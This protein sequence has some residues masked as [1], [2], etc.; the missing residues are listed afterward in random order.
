MNIKTFM[1]IRCV[2]TPNILLVNYSDIASIIL[3]S[4]LSKETVF[5]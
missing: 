1:Y 5:W 4:Q 2:F 3:L